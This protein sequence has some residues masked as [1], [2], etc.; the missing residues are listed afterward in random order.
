MRERPRHV[1]R[2]ATM[3][4]V[5]RGARPAENRRPRGRAAPDAGAPQLVRIRSAR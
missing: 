2:P 4:R 5:L 1:L 3:R